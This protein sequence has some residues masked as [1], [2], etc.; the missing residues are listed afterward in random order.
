MLN[1]AMFGQTNL[2]VFLSK[3]TTRLVYGSV[4]HASY[5]MEVED[6]LSAQLKLCPSATV[7]S[8]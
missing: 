2:P 6:S 8:N 1:E 4:F 5:V 3:N 7:L